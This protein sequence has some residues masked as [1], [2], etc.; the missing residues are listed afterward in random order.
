MNLGQLDWSK[1][2]CQDLCFKV[3]D[4]AQS[5]VL[6]SKTTHEL[7]NRNISR[8]AGAVTNE[9]VTKTGTVLVLACNGHWCPFLIGVILY[10]ERIP[11][12]AYIEWNKQLS[13]L[14]KFERTNGSLTLP[15]FFL[16]K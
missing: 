8:A 10:M 2:R 16:S 9:A 12:A 7:H 14:L 6:S 1:H 13:N 11:F 5:F 15:S 3:R 4:H